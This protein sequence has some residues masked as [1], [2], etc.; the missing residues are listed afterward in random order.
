MLPGVAVGAPPDNYHIIYG[1]ESYLRY[2]L[3]FK[4]RETMVY[5]G[6]NDGMLH[7]FT[8]WYYDKS[9][10]EFTLPSGTTDPIGDEVWAYIPQNL[11]PHL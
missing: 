8:S 7:A 3:A 5:V 2:Y 6:A 10:R 9:A 4:G 11:L 1:D